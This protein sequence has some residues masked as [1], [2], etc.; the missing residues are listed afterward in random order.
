LKSSLK[1]E[2]SPSNRFTTAMQSI[3]KY[4]NDLDH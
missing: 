4:H 3:E 2:S 1:Q